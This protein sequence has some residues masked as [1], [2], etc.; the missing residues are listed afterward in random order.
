MQTGQC[1]K[2]FDHL[3]TLAIICCLP[4]FSAAD[5]FHFNSA[6]Q[7][8]YH[9]AVSLRLDNA[10]ALSTKEKEQNPTNLIPYLVDDYIDFL[11]VFTSEDAALYERLKNNKSARLNLLTGGNSES[12]YYLYSQA[13][14][15]LHWAFLGIRFGEYFSA[16]LDMRQAY[17]LLAKNERSNPEFAPNLKS[18]GLL[19]VLLGTIPDKYH[20]AIRLA[21]MEG[22]I[23]KGII[24]LQKSLQQANEGKSFYRNE[25]VIIYAMLQSH[26]LG[27]GE[28]AW[29]IIQTNGLPAEDNLMTYFA[30][31]GIALFS[32]HNDE[33]ASILSGSPGGSEYPPF[34]Q[35][36]LLMGA[37][38][39]QR[40]DKA[41][42]AYY[43]RFLEKARGKDHIKEAYQKLAWNRLIQEDE[44]GYKYYISLAIIYGDDAIDADKQAMDEAKSGI[45]PNPELLKARL[46]FDGG[47][48]SRSLNIL[49]NIAVNSLKTEMHQVEYHYRLGR[50]YHAMGEY[51]KA[52]T[53]YRKSMK[54]GYNR[55]Y[56]FAASAALHSG[57]LYAEQ[58][59][60]QK[61]LSCFEQCLGTKEHP[62]K[63]SL[64]Q[65]AKAAIGRL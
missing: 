53:A 24:Q 16:L 21:G 38:Y 45:A 26:V 48:L 49:E 5:E 17:K 39:L 64:D 1:S 65:K 44:Q 42:A 2:G 55:P 56:Y 6:C 7:T 18:L 30:A 28:T 47:Y 59:D 10:R 13:E 60:K 9:E 4:L 35:L 40:L 29:E 32:K 37:A 22:N 58:G 51:D 27:D 57:H 15:Y 25:I 19:H 14:V 36:N 63:N 3:L 11:A 43:H 34:P 12:P 61:A 20:W 33:A 23:S 62:Y 31:G 54:L 41:S 46:L 8:A 52:L 50:V